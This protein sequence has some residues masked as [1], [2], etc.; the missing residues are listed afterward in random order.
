MD[1]VATPS[2]RSLDT[3]RTDSK[4]DRQK[5]SHWLFQRQTLKLQE[6]EVLWK[7]DD[8]ASEGEEAAPPLGAERVLFPSSIKENHHE[9]IKPAEDDLQH[10]AFNG[11]CN[12][13]GDT[14][15]A[16][17]VG[18]TID[19]SFRSFSP[20]LGMI[21]RSCMSLPRGG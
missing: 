7:D 8:E 12:K 21:L 6:E 18:G 3:R 4:F 17:W 10:A 9:T 5:L 1:R 2:E 14:C 19:V 11:R 13:I 16:F 15:Y 20:C